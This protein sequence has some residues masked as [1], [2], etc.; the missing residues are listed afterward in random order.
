MSG[1]VTFHAETSEFVAEPPEHRKPDQDLTA[2]ALRLRVRQQ[3]ILAELGVLALQ[4]THFTELLDLTARLVAEGLQAE[5]SKVLEYMPSEGRF[6]VR[7]GVGWDPGVIGSATVGADAA[8]PAGYALQT[9]KA[10]ISNHLE[11]EERFRTP[12]LL[13]EHGIHRAMNVILE[14]EG[15]P[16]GVLEVDSR[17]E[18][19]F[20]TKD[21]TFLQGAANILGMAI[22]RQRADRKLKD[23]LERHQLMIK[24]VNHR[25][26]NSLQ[27]VAS[28]LHLQTTTTQSDEVR[29]A[30]HDASSRIAAIARAHQRLYGSDQ[31]GKVD[32]GAYLGDICNDLGKAMP[33]CK[34]H[35]AAAPDIHCATDTAIPVALLVNELITNSAKYAYPDGGCEVWLDV[36]RSGDAISISVRDRGIGLPTEFDP[37]SGKRL[38]MRLVSALSSQVHADLQVRRLRPGTEFLL[39]IPA[40]LAT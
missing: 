27:I 5:F 33:D 31:I 19:E 18:G 40:P 28:M 3:E 30:L 29:H 12:E 24:E 22:Y 36:S 21:I 38:G 20:S 32:L 10:V 4:G 9:G 14:G 34:I 2:E 7:A 6:L 11:N 23:A 8:S 37:N 13:L 15:A 39:S 26:N 17:S 25:I 1:V 16:F 35:V